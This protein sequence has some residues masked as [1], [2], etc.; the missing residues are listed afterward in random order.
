MSLKFYESPFHVTHEENIA[1]KMAIK[2]DFCI[3][4]SMIIEE[5]FENQTKAAEALGVHQSRIS[6]IK[7]GKIE[8]FTID[9]IL[10]ILDSIKEHCGQ[11][12]S[13]KEVSSAIK[14]I[15]AA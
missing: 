12:Y 10:D 5:K 11:E 4:V 3:T 1:T 13:L 6:D 8:N 9:A 2:M 7:N 15:T 14:N